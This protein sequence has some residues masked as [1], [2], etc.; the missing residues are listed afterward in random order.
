MKLFQT[1]LILYQIY[2]GR[3]QFLLGVHVTDMD[4]GILVGQ[5]QGVLGLMVL[6]HIG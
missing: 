1:D 3:Y 2:C 5:C 4:C 6:G